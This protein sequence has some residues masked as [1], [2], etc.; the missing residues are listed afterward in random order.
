MKNNIEA[1]F[2]IQDHNSWANAVGSPLTLSASDF[3]SAELLATEKLDV[4]VELPFDIRVNFD[5]RAQRFEFDGEWVQGSISSDYS[6][7]VPGVSKAIRLQWLPRKRTLQLEPMEIPHPGSLLSDHR[8]DV[9]CKDV[10]VYRGLVTETGLPFRRAQSFESLKDLFDAFILGAEPG[11]GDPVPFCIPTDDR[12]NFIEDEFDTEMQ[13]QVTASDTDISYFRLFQAAQHYAGKID[14][15]SQVGEL[16]QW[17]FSRPG[18]LLELVEK[19]K[20][21]IASKESVVF[22]WFLAQEV[23]ALCKL[24]DKKRRK[25]G[26]SDESL[27]AGRWEALLVA[28][29]RLPRG[30]QKAYANLIQKECSYARP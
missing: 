19:A 13:T 9:L 7:K 20:V 17:V 26:S 1:G 25:L 14:A 21:K 10:N 5:W 16:N 3:A 6:I 24:A 12:N 27:P 18:C 8:F 4:P 28:V 22:N 23:N 11:V 15:I 29:P 30:I 2:L